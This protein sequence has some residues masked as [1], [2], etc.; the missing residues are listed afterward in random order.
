V[1]KRK[2][3]TKTM[4]WDDVDIDQLFSSLQEKNVEKSEK[5]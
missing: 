4:A 3:E 5:K 2:R 1:K